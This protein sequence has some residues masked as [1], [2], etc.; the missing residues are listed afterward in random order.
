MTPL[1][2]KLTCP[3][4]NH[5]NPSLFFKDEHRTY[6]LCNHCAL[7]VVPQRYWLSAEEEKA[8]YDLHENHVMD[9]GYRRFLSRLAIPLQKKLAPGQRGLD[10]GCGPGPALSVLLEEAGHRVNLYDPFYFNDPQLL[11]ETYDFITATEVLEHLQDPG[12]VFA[13]LFDRLKPGGWLG[14]MTGLIIDRQAFQNWHYIR[15][16]THICFYSRDTFEYLA[17]QF[18]ADIL[19]AGNNVIL[20][21]KKETGPG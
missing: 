17:R 12:T 20:L 2:Q 19:F 10:F 8:V 13:T 18:N 9:P 4:C 1:S 5:R 11:E 3:L 16:L 14:I 6:L 15:D 21:N 7:V